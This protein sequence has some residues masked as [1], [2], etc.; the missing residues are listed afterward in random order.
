M[1]KI[2][3]GLPVPTTPLQAQSEQL[4][5]L[6]REEIRHQASASISFAR[7]MQLALYEPE[8]GYYTAALDKFGKAGDF[9]TAPEI[10]PLFARCIGRQC[11]QVFASLGQSDILEI[12]AGTGQLAI[13]LLLFLEKEQSLP[14][15]YKIFEISP[16]LRQRQQQRLQQHMPHLFPLIQWLEDW[17]AMP[18]KGVI[19][20]N[21]VVDALPV[22]QFLWTKD[23]IQEV[24]VGVEKDHFKYHLTPIDS[25]LISQL[26]QLQTA[27]FPGAKDYQSEVS[28]GL[29]DWVS[30]LNQALEQGLVLI[31]DYGFPAQ[32]YY[33][34]DRMNGT[35]L[36]YYQH[37]A[38]ADPLSLVGLQDIT[39]SVDFSGLARAALQSGLKVSGYTSQAAFLLNNDLLPLIEKCY[40]EISSMDVNR[41][42]HL[43]TSPSEM[44]ELIKVMGLTRN[45]EF[46]PLNGFKLYDKRTRL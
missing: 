15:T 36:C 34:P 38:H 5:Q 18:I 33:H 12:G 22:H 43:L 25:L 2:P 14:R 21:E 10:S 11:Q 29:T 44:G 7:F 24:R 45:C 28:T 23:S 32:E 1:I 40:D 20:A 26:S 37:R 35:L 46:S 42:V 39:A 27:Y 41:Q 6:I 8:L 3:L 9:T 13:D 31:I 4:C 30:K 17:P 19:L 16:T